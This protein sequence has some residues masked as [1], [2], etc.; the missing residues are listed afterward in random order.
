MRVGVDP[1]V[2]VSA[3]GVALKF[4]VG[5]KVVVGEAKIV[6]GVAAAAPGSAAWEGDDDAAVCG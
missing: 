1:G 4:S 6:E 5:E 3:G 2:G